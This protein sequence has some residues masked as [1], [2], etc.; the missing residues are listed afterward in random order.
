LYDLNLGLFMGPILR[1]ISLL[2][3][4]ACAAI[5]SQPIQF[6]HKTHVALGMNCLDC[7]STAD[8]RAEAGIPSVRKCMLCHQRVAAQN[9]EVKK[10]AEYSA[11]KQEIPWE[12]VYGFE[13]SAAVKFQHAPHIRANVA[14]ATCHGDMSQATVA[15]PFIKFTMGTCVSC[16]RQKN[17]SED[18]AACHY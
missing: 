13:T 6:P 8:T 15:Q 12:R 17:A 5:G 4:L 14:C 11:K 10:V 3:V 1:G 9:P 7:H 18:C 16:H 2:G